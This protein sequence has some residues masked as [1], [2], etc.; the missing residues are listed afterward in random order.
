MR[1]IL[2]IALALAGVAPVISAPAAPAPLIAAHRGG[3]GFAP[4][5]TL[6]AFRHAHTRWGSQGVWLE[7]DLKTTSDGVPM[8]LHDPELSRTTTCVGRL[9]DR[10]AADVSTCDTRKSF[11]SWPAFEGIPTFEQVLDEGCEAG[12][13]LMVEVKEIPIDSDFDPLLGKLDAFLAALDARTD[14]TRAQWADRIMV[15][16]FWPPLLEELALR[17]PEFRAILLTIAAP[18]VV[19]SAG[20]IARQFAISAP[21]EAGVTAEGI[22]LAHAGG[23]LVVPWTVNDA[24]RQQQLLLM[25]VDGLITDYPE[26]VLG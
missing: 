26:R 16:S 15:Q 21:D 8:I 2:I 25:G 6:A 14:C 19:G 5:N 10:T 7:M 23:R 18:S 13:R 1:R 22:D 17:A 3:K 12:W 9:V 24:S 20:A 11:P 4:E